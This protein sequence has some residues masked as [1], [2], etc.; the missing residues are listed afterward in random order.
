MMD[1]YIMQC[2]YRSRYLVLIMPPSLSINMKNINLIDHSS[3]LKQNL[4][5]LLNQRLVV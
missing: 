1:I 3:L 4:N 2:N 5:F